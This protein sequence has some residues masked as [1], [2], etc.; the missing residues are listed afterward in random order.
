MS[1]V[2]SQKEPAAPRRS[3]Y[4][5]R[6]FNVLSFDKLCKLLGVD[7]TEAWCD[8]WD[9]CYYSEGPADETEEERYKRE[10]EDR[11]EAWKA[12]ESAVLSVAEHVFGE[13]DLA[14][15]PVEKT[16]PYKGR[17]KYVAGYAVTPKATSTWRDAANK[18]RETLNGMGPFYFSTLSEF[19]RSGPYTP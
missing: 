1:P 15:T 3:T 7:N 4:R 11:D 18:I 16:S 9:R 5:T 8:S 14:L 12:Y 10:E 6:G 13:H 19:L 17:H 2:L